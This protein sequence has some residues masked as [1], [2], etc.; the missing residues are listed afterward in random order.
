MPRRILKKYFPNPKKI[1]DNKCLKIFGSLLHSPELWHFSRNSIAKA[2]A[3]GLFC[4]WIPIPFQMVLAAGFAI[5]FSANLP[6]S[7]ALVWITNPFTMAPMFYIAY[8]IGA[9]IMGVGEV[10]FKMELT[11]D[12]LINGT[13]LIWQPFLLGCFALASISALLGYFGIQ[14]FWRWAVMRRWKQRKHGKIR[15]GSNNKH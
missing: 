3:I 8:K 14:I 6:M 15:A 13:L 2:F 5:L 7:A 1:R 4:A 12:W 10:P 11:L 9:T